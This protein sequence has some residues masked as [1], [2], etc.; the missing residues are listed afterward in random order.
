[1]IFHDSNA[2]PRWLSL[3]GLSVCAPGCL[4]EFP[5]QMTLDAG[6]PPS[7]DCSVS[8]GN[9]RLDVWEQCD[10]TELGGASCTEL[11][12]Y[13]G[14]LSCHDNCMFDL[15]ECGDKC[16]DG[17]VDV[18]EQ[19]DGSDFSGRTCVEMGFGAG[20][21]RCSADCAVIDIACHNNFCGNGG[22]DAGE[23]CDGAD[24]AG[25]TCVSLGHTG[26]VLDC[27][28]CAFN[29]TACTRCGNHVAE[30]GEECDFPDLGG[31]TCIGLGYAGGGLLSCTVGCL[32][33]VEGC[34][35]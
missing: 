26:G 12:F 29:E 27:A 15:T 13:G 14:E 4:A 9:G 17:V 25:H 30:A 18:G 22:I 31:M 28:E 24:L 33:N 34:H 10:G 20:I 5:D 21:L 35:P 6:S 3:L 8:C 23:D 32:F 1:M 7:P 2:V 19:C 11:G 16:G